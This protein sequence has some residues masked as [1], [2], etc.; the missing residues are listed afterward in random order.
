[1]DENF[2]D[3][4]AEADKIEAIQTEEEL[5]KYIETWAGGPMSA[6]AWYH[7]YKVPGLGFKTPKQTVEQYGLEPVKTLICQIHYGV[8]I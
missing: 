2:K 6:K 7:E 1:M 5:L 8:Y 4:F 3:D